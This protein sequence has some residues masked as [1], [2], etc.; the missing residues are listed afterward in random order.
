MINR[1]LICEEICRH[2]HTSRRN[3]TRTLL[4]KREMLVILRVLIQQRQKLEQLEAEVK[5]L[6][7]K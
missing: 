7:N 5:V 3:P 4:S 2:V 1:I 6:R